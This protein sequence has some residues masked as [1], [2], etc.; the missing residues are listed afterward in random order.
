MRTVGDTVWYIQ[1]RIGGGEWD[2]P[3]VR[4]HVNTTH[5]APEKAVA[6][7]DMLAAKWEAARL[8]SPLEYASP[9]RRYRV[10]EEMEIFVTKV[11]KPKRSEP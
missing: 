7:R 1:E 4:G 3:D 11:Y 9:R 8:R 2:A 5:D 6:E 10:M